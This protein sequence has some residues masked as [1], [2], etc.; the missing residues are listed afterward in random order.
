MDWSSRRR[1]V[2]NSAHGS[3]LFSK[4]NWTGRTVSFYSPVLTNLRVV[5]SFPPTASLPSSES[6]LSLWR[7]STGC[8]RYI[9]SRY[10]RPTED[11]VDLGQTLTTNS[12]GRHCTSPEF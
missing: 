6:P 5:W 11:Y 3:R 7:R 4:A 8:L 10:L 12:R 2:V 9:L 1:T